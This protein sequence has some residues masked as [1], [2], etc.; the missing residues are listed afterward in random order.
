MF[1][2]LAL[3]GHRMIA[4]MKSENVHE[5]LDFAKETKVTGIIAEE[6]LCVDHS[7]ERKIQQ[8]HHI[9]EAFRNLIHG[10]EYG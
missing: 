8:E 7:G 9:N 5:V 2:L 4:L 6:Y 1:F 3:E 10:E